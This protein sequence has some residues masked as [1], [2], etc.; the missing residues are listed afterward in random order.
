MK[1]YVCMLPVALTMKLL[2]LSQQ[3]IGT[4][5]NIPDWVLVHRADT[6]NN[7]IQFYHRD[8]ETVSSITGPDTNQFIHKLNEIFE[9]YIPILPYAANIFGNIPTIRL[10]KV[11]TVINYY[12]KLFSVHIYTNS[13]SFA[14]CY[15]NWCSTFF[16][17]KNNIACFSLYGYHCNNQPL[18]FGTNL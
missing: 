1:I 15:D 14:L 4:D 17:A 3:T 7:L 8:L 6:L 18:V 5:Q 10:P 9:T 2:C 13:C 12:L 16:F 11:S